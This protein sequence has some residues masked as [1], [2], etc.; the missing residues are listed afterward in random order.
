MNGLLTYARQVFSGDLYATERTE[1]E[2]TDIAASSTSP[3]GTATAQL[4]LHPCHRNAMGY[5]MGGVYFTLG[6]LAFAAASNAGCLSR[7]E[8]LQWVS[9]SSTI[10]YLAAAQGDRLLASAHCEREGR[11]TCLYTIRVT[12]GCSNLV[13]QIETIGTRLPAHH[14]AAH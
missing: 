3:G 5:V 7:R 10:H 9:L 8:P 4:Y 2:L 14:T 13:A 11:T 6:D 1:A 12:D